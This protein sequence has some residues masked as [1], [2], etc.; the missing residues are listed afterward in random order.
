MPAV[1]FDGDRFERVRDGR[2]REHAALHGREVL[3]D[4]LLQFA[5]AFGERVE[6]AL[7]DARQDAH[8]HEMAQVRGKRARKRARATRGRAVRRRRAGLRGRCRR[9]AAR[10]MRPG[11]AGETGAAAAARCRRTDGRR[12]R[13]R[14]SARRGRSHECR[15]PSARRVPAGARSAPWWRCVRRRARTP[16]RPPARAACPSP[17]RCARAAFRSLRWRPAARHTLRATV[18]DTVR[19]GRVCAALPAP[20]TRVASASRAVMRVPCP[21]IVRPTLPNARPSDAFGSMKPRCRRAGASTVTADGGERRPE[22]ICIAIV[23]WLEVEISSGA[24]QTDSKLPG[25]VSRAFE[26]RGVPAV[27]ARCGPC[28]AHRSAR[29]SARRRAH[30]VT[31]APECSRGGKQTAQ[32]LGA[33]YLM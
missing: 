7:R 5:D 24:G 15:C 32:A 19:C 17:A 12:G 30:C 14:P 33:S 3:A 4:G 31:R 29:Q 21:S 28:R 13:R 9:R 27:Q 20:S 26:A 10:A 6:V 18:P 23:P 2:A 8:Q 1:S 16:C 22:G 25:G 11:T